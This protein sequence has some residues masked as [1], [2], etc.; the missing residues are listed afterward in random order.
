MHFDAGARGI[1]IENHI[2]MFLIGEQ[3]ECTH[4]HTCSGNYKI[5]YRETSCCLVGGWNTCNL[6]YNLLCC[7]LAH[8]N[9]HTHRHQN[10]FLIIFWTLLKIP[11]GLINLWHICRVIVER[12][13]ESSMHLR[14][15]D[16]SQEASCKN[17]LSFHC[18]TMYFAEFQTSY[19]FLHIIWTKTDWIRYNKD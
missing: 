9:T 16:W 11:H 1:N 3:Q 13:W 8:T 10:T 2:N 5:I 14:I 4:A 6:W 7:L 15:F 18:F 12:V 17:S 19:K